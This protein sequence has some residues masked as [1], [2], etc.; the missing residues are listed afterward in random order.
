MNHQL[1]L[2]ISDADPWV[3]YPFLIA[4]MFGLLSIAGMIVFFSGYYIL[5]LMNWIRKLLTGS[6]Q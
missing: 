3:L 1:L 6:K 5:K 4:I 2:G